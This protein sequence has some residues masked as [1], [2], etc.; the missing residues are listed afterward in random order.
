[1]SW[2][3][4]ALDNTRRS[5]KAAPLLHPVRGLKHLMPRRLFS[6]SLMIIVMPM[7]LLQTVVTIVFFDRHYRI[8]TAVMTR[9]VVNDIGYMVMLENS[10]PPGLERDRQ[11]QVAADMFGYTAQFLPGE[12]LTR[13]VSAPST[14][15]DRQLDFTLSSQ[16]AQDVSFD[17]AGYPDHVDVRMQVQDGVLRLLIPRE[18]V[19][20]SSADIFVLW[21]IGS[22]LVLI[23]IAV[24][25]LRNQ[26][27][28]IERLA[29]AAES[30]G[31]GRPVADFKPHGATE[32]R[33]AATAFIQMRE[34]IDR[35]V[36]QRTEMLAGI[37]HDLKTP[38]TRM[39][40]QLAMM[41]KDGDT[42]A[43]QADLAEMERMLNEYLEFARGEGSDDVE[44]VAL[45]GLVEE[46]VADARRAH[47][48]GEQV[49][50]GSLEDVSIAVRRQAL[51][52][53]LTNLIDNALK[54][55]RRAELSVKRA[56]RSVEIAVEDDGPGISE[57]RREEA[58]RPFHRLDEGR[59]LQA[60]GVG[61]G[62]TIARD[63]A[64][65]HGGNVLLLDGSRGGLRA[66]IRLP[67]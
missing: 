46:A 12:Q 36:Q 13:T 35:F 37:S 48:P 21:M 9:G 31:K 34:R 26:V 43:M 63:I 32:V 7:I 11:R 44:P 65:A 57:E 29:A 59:N 23:A 49:R 5:L 47:P 45:A 53:C 4:T 38:L 20:A 8:T 61:L 17:T 1:M 30:F 14:V 64:R 16:F 22:S 24:L 54:Y 27:K 18:R 25:F 41:A 15:L 52:R 3:Q 67:I 40:L 56:G 42:D 60:G 28:P 39:R 66:V 55:G 62:L 33:K 50:L 58:F 6:R 10:E 51:K 2:S 19:T